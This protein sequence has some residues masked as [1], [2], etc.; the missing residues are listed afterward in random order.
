MKIKYVI[1][2][3][4]Y[5]VVISEC[6]KHSDVRAMGPIT[7]A[8]FFAFKEEPDN[9][10][11]AICPTKLAVDVWGESVSLGLKSNPADALI[12]ERLLN[13]LP[14]TAAPTKTGR[15]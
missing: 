10:P 6:H 15:K 5:P 11:T 13:S 14:L 1:I 12:L 3:E 4:A 8:G 2:D 7:S 9:S